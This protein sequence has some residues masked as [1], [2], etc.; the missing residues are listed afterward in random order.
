VGPVAPVVPE[1]PV[2]PVTP[3]VLVT[4]AVRVISGVSVTPVAP[5]KPVAQVASGTQVNPV[6]PG[7]PVAT[8]GPCA[9]A[10]P[11]V[12]VNFGTPVNP[13]APAKTKPNMNPTP[14]AYAPNRA[15]ANLLG[16][17]IVRSPPSTFFRRTHLAP[18]GKHRFLTR[19]KRGRS[20]YGEGGGRLPGMVEIGSFF[21]GGQF[22]RLSPNSVFSQMYYQPAAPRLPPLK[23]AFGEIGRDW[24]RSGPPSEY[25]FGDRLSEPQHSGGDA[26]L[27]S[28]L[29]SG[30]QG[31]SFNSDGTGL[32]IPMVPKRRR[33]FYEFV[34]F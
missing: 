23:G 20:I 1:T 24:Q 14:A 15:P 6:E 4:P 33:I 30:G 13:S 19:R 32:L 16:Q 7:I 29:F 3:A 34:R 5:G 12:S 18:M 2:A 26:L 8:A 22:Q 31:R 17:S 11:P 9:P 10:S 21:Q 28:S 25:P 27:A